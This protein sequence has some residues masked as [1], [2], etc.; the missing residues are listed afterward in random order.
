MPKFIVD[1]VY[2]GTDSVLV[3]ESNEEEAAVQAAELWSVNSGI[4][5]RGKTEF[6]EIGTVRAADSPIVAK[7]VEKSPPKKPTVW[8]LI[9][10]K[11]SIAV[12]V[13]R[14]QK[15]AL[16]GAAGV[17][18]NT[19][20]ARGQTSEDIEAVV[21][22]LLSGQLEKGF[23]AWNQLCRNDC[24]LHPSLRIEERQVFPEGDL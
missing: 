10:F 3:E 11:E 22:A 8:L 16:Q 14:T 17:I 24:T 4:C 18:L 23:L 2:S 13:Y 6:V 9:Q 20:D 19:L 7:A 5:V 21:Q 12:G 15:G 1:V